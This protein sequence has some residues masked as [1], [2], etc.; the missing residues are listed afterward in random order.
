M[1]R[2]VTLPSQLRQRCSNVGPESALVEAALRANLLPQTANR[3]S[4][5]LQPKLPL[6]FPD[7]VIVEYRPEVL[8][9]LQNEASLHTRHLQLI[10]YLHAT[11]AGS[12]SDMSRRLGRSAR[13]L[14]RDA[15]TLAAA[16]LI[17]L[18]LDT[19][20]PVALHRVFAVER[21]VAVEAKVREWRKALL[22]ARANTWFASE[23]YVLL[24]RVPAPEGIA[25]FQKS[26]V[27]LIVFDGSLCQTV[28]GAAIQQQPVSYGS[29]L[30]NEWARL[31]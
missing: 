2:K 29:W 25:E 17:V 28:C 20:V 21:I 16:G 31:R 15:V 11:G 27:G 7:I 5:F 8:D 23:S 22:Q 19:V 3:V 26:G 4:V 18:Y 10:Q 1:I 14:R 30:F 12:V 13:A 6:G 9:A 24:P